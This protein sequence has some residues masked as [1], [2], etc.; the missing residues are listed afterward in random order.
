[1]ARN[2]VHALSWSEAEI[3][4]GESI[5]TEKL[6]KNFIVSNKCGTETRG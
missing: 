1:M 5:H 2:E 6:D 4:G 3:I